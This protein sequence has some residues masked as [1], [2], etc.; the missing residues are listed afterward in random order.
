MP[1][2]ELTYCQDF[3]FRKTKMFGI[4]N[5]LQEKRFCNFTVPQDFFGLK[6]KIKLPIYFF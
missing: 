2:V 5:E 4:R 6:C 1:F 3:E